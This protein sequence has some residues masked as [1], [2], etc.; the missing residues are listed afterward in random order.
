MYHLTAYFGIV[1]PLHPRQRQRQRNPHSLP[2]PLLHPLTPHPHPKPSK[3]T[4]HELGVHG[5]PLA[6]WVNTKVGKFL[7]TYLSSFI[8]ALGTKS[9]ICA[10]Q[11]VTDGWHVPP[12]LLV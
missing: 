1:D 4:H 10:R 9:G 8:R 7:T 3:T 11:C 6:T 12:E 2:R 5:K